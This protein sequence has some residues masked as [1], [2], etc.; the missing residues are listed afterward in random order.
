MAEMTFDGLVMIASRFAYI[1]CLSLAHCLIVSFRL[2]VWRLRLCISSFLQ[3][4][5][6]KHS[7]A[8]TSRGRPSAKLGHGNGDLVYLRSDVGPQTSKD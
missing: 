2:G 5:L 1:S 6:I 3:L 7:S 4:E 8:R